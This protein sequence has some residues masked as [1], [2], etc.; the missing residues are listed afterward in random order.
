MKKF[1]MGLIIGL[2]VSLGIVTYAS[3]NQ[4]ISYFFSQENQKPDVQLVNLINSAKSTCDISIYSLTKP[5]IVDAIVKAK[6][7]GVIVRVISDKTQS[8]G[9]SQKVALDT[10]KIVKIPVKINKHSGLMH[11]KDV[12][13][14]NSIVTTGSFNYSKAA[15]ENNDE[16]FVIIKEKKIAEDFHN[17]FEKMWNDNKRFTDY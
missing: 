6:K 15:A 7:R 10:L 17:E 4:T 13:I 14:D 2:S 9:K 11:M 5:N 1:I 16:V 12:I 3:N 8:K